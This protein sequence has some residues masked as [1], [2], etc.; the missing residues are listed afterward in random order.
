[1]NEDIKRLNAAL[2]KTKHDILVE[3]RLADRKVVHLDNGFDVDVE[4]YKIE[5]E[6]LSEKV[7][8]MATI[9]QGMQGQQKAKSIGPR[10][11]LISA[12]NT[13]DKQSITN[14]YLQCI[15][16]LREQLK[17]S[18]NEVKR[19]H[20]VLN[21]PNKYAKGV[22]DY[23][24]DIREKSEQLS[25]V[26]SRYEKTQLQNETNIK[27]LEHTRKSLDD[28]ITRYNEERR[29]NLDNEN[30][31]QLMEVK[32]AKLPELESLLE[33]YKH[34]ERHLE[35]T[36]NDL[37]ENPFIK[38]AEQRG[39]IY[40]KAQENELA[41]SEANRRLKTLEDSNRILERENKNIKEEL[42]N[43]G[44][45][46][47]RFKEDAMRYKITNEERDKYSKDWE[48][49]LRMLGQ[50]GEVDSNLTKIL[51]LLK[52]KDDNTS[53]MK[54]DLL[55]KINQ[56]GNTDPV[57]LLREI[58]KLK[59]EKGLLG[60]ELEKT[61]SL[62]QI[63][64]Q[65]N[66]DQQKVYDEDKKICKLQIEKLM[67]KC[68]ELSKLVDLERL[69][70]DHMLRGHLRSSNPDKLRELLLNDLLPEERLA[71]LMNDTITEFSKDETETDFG[72][73]ENCLDIYVGEAIFEDGLERE[74]GFKVSNMMSFC[75]LDFY[76]H[77]PQLSHLNNGAKPIYNL[78]V[79]FKVNVDENFINY[80]QSDN[81]LVD[82][83][84][85][86]D[87]VQAI[88]GRG[89]IPLSQIL[90]A[91]NPL[92]K[93]TSNNSS[94]TRV[95]NNVCTIKYVRDQS[96][97]IGH[98]HYKMRIRKPILEIIKWFKDKNQI[99]REISPVQDVMMKKV[100]KELMNL[101]NYSKGKVMSVSVLLTKAI[102]LKTTGPPRK[103]MP[104]AYY[105]FYKFDA[106]FTKTGFGNDPLFS[107]VQKFDVVY[108]NMFHEYVNNGCLEIIILDDSRALEVQMKQE[109][110]TTNTVNLVDSPE[111]DDFIGSA[112]IKLRD[113]LINGLIQNNFP[114]YNQNGQLSGEIAINIFWEQV[115]LDQDDKRG[116]PYETRAWEEDIVKRLAEVMKQ[117]KLRLDSAFEI[118]DRDKKQLISLVNFRDTV[119][120]TFNFTN[121]QEELEQLTS[122]VFNG[123]ANLSKLDFHKIFC[124]LL[125]GEEN[126]EH[127][128]PAANYKENKIVDNVSIAIISDQPRHP[129]PG[130]NTY[131]NTS[132]DNQHMSF[133]KEPNV[134]FKKDIRVQSQVFND[135]NR[136]IKEIV[137]CINEYMFR[138]KKKLIV[139]V[140]KMFDKD[141]NSFLD[142]SVNSILTN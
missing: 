39:N 5:N 92:D 54:M 59:I 3:R 75:S 21:G 93:L 47:D 11:N 98:V 68:E 105:Q 10:K 117:K 79:S 135:S 42:Q 61:K 123:K 9:I 126:I 107:D 4:T 111:I 71:N 63:Q 138:T 104:Y 6:K 110:A 34:K 83:Y 38:D 140:Y 99:I 24:K 26:Q 55:D 46:R 14:E 20:G 36:I 43:T 18:E 51:N 56:P 1:L 2:E 114:I 125:P 141:A 90:E 78:Q 82:I 57:T 112:K 13:L 130:K 28:Y 95:V 7:K 35:R 85:V 72:L 89:A 62:L 37:C 48:E 84:Y 113:L 22:G 124:Y 77:E 132:H 19:L 25:D 119:L 50:Y 23:S 97:M 16:L 91:E 80:L 134:D 12:K 52:L 115:A 33:E 116:L 31:C 106:H 49:Q 41:L 128:I 45:D 65:I 27:I 87:N 64:Q 121:K 53:W 40:R 44:A 88:L 94:L 118:F 101:G 136:N 108:D 133:R 73:N 15:N 122:L 66:D 103:I 142:K 74:L 129:S 137:A 96:I 8:K 70:K 58:E 76:L 17:S 67:K 109:N 29:K 86:K 69:P 139:D 100:E 60:S 30:R 102:H 120:F 131:M 127:L 81:I 32:L